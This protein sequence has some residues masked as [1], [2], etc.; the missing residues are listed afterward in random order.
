MVYQR[1]KLVKSCEVPIVSLEKYESQWDGLSHV[2]IYI[3]LIHDAMNFGATCFSHR[4]YFQSYT[5]G[6]PKTHPAISNGDAWCL[7][8]W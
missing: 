4:F 1:V 2:Y 8:T 7:V 5:N 3:L 6:S